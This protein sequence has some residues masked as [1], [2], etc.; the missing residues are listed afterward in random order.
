M[1]ASIT[2]P[3]GKVIGNFTSCGRVKESLQWINVSSRS[4]I[5]VFLPKYKIKYLSIPLFEVD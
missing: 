2:S 5:S 1:P 3:F 4:K